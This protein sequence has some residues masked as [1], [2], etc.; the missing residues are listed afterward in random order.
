MKIPLPV[1]LI[2]LLFGMVAVAMTIGWTSMF[3]RDVS[4]QSLDLQIAFVAVGLIVVG[5][6][7]WICLGLVRGSRDARTIALAFCWLGFIGVPIRVVALFQDEP[8]KGLAFGLVELAVLYSIYRALTS[9]S[10]RKDI[11]RCP[12]PC[13]S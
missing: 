10:I 13:N 6:S 2:A 5:T 9:P 1:R 4:Q 12:S 7:G 3:I 11:F 8:M